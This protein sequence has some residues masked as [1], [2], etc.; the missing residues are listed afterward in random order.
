MEDL[1]ATWEK[2]DKTLEDNIPTLQKAGSAFSSLSSGISTLINA[3]K[4]IKELVIPTSEDYIN[5]LKITTDAIGEFQKGLASFDPTTLF[6]NMEDLT[7]TWE[8]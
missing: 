6:K 2:Y 3:Y 5:F 7:A 4:D 1:T 8:F